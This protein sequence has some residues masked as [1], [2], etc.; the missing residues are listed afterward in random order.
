MITNESCTNFGI[1]SVFS[2]I[3]F[4]FGIVQTYSETICVYATAPNCF[5]ICLF[6]Y[7]KGGKR[8]IE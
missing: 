7:N 3:W 4:Y 8:Q 1:I 5:K 2:G 6:F